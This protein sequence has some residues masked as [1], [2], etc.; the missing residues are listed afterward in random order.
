[1]IIQ[2][3]TIVLFIPI[4]NKHLDCKKSPE[5]EISEWRDAGQSHLFWTNRGRGNLIW[6]E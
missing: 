4:A 1:M 2:S 5:I 3:P 6:W